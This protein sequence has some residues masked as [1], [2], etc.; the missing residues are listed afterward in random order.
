MPG[1]LINSEQSGT[2]LYD[3]FNAPHGL[4]LSCGLQ[5]S[6]KANGGAVVMSGGMAYFASEGPVR[7]CFYFNSGLIFQLRLFVVLLT[8]IKK[9]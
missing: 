7:F 8:L 1:L 6:A 5:T 2:I 9:K 3:P 4:N